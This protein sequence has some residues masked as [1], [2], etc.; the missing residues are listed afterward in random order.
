MSDTKAG[1][2]RQVSPSIRVAES[3]HVVWS[4]SAQEAEDLAY[5]LMGVR[6]WEQDGHL[7]LEAALPGVE[8]GKDD[9]CA[10]CG[11]ALWVCRGSHIREA[12]LVEPSRGY[13]A[14]PSSP[15]T[16]SACSVTSGRAS[17]A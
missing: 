17:G 14:T 13:G 9:M 1:E 15:S 7:L 5:V 3:G 6:S 4:L 11:G 8:L 12:K 2:P 16:A 10:Y